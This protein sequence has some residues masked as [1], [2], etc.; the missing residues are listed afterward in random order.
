MRQITH[1]TL[2]NMYINHMFNMFKM[3]TTISIDNMCIYDKFF[4]F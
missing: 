2:Y 4:Q 3:Y 1:S